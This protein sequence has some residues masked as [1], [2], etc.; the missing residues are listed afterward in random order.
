MIGSDLGKTLG[1]MITVLGIVAC[2]SDSAMTPAAI[3]IG[4]IGWTVG[5]FSV[6]LKFEDTE[7]LRARRGI[8]YDLALWGY[9]PEGYCGKYDPMRITT[10]CKGAN[11]DKCYHCIQ[12]KMG[13]TPVETIKSIAE[14]DAFKE[15]KDA[16]E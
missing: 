3:V 1:I 12:A 15:A 4:S 10:R 14:H 2:F 5:G 7:S 11:F 6:P 16:E 8:S 13:D 9:C